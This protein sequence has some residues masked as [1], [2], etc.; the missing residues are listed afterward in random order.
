MDSPM[1]YQCMIDKKR[2]KCLIPICLF[3][4]YFRYQL[5]LHRLTA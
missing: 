3:D 5:S 4:V 2:K 1:V